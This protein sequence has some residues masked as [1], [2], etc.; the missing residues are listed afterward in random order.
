[1]SALST[2]DPALRDWHIRNGGHAFDEITV[3]GILASDLVAEYGTPY[4]AKVD[5]EGFDLI[6]LEG[7]G[8]APEAPTYLSS[9]VDFRYLERQISLMEGMGYDRFALV[10]QAERAKDAP[11]PASP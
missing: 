1:M 11:T 6:C 4:F 10:P 5:I 8:S 2:A 9:E 3:S 7:L